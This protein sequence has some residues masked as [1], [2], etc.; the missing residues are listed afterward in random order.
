MAFSTD[1]A[2]CRAKIEDT[3]GTDAEPARGTDDLVVTKGASIQMGVQHAEIELE[4][5]YGGLAPAPRT[6]IAPTISFTV[7]LFG[8]GFGG[9][10]SIIQQTAFMSAI[11]QSCGDIDISGSSGEVLKWTP[12]TWDTK[13]F[14]DESDSATDKGST[15]TFEGD[16]GLKG[17][18]D[19]G[20]TTTYTVVGCRVQS[21]RFQLN[22]QG[23]CMC[24]VTAAGVYASQPADVTLDSGTALTDYNPTF[25]ADFITANGL[26]TIFGLTTAGTSQTAQSNNFEISVDFGATHVSGDDAESGVS[27]TR[28]GQF[29]VTATANPVRVLQSTWDYWDQIFSPLAESGSARDKRYIQT[30]KVTPARRAADEGYSWQFFLPDVTYGGE[31]ERGGEVHRHNMSVRA[32]DDF[33]GELMYIQVT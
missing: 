20:T 3:E 17:R 5:P 24:E 30:S 22:A 15:F 25:D 14:I 2:I 18:P 26:T 29:R 13:S 31:D 23:V 1:F 8:A 12:N 9:D 28:N 19:S 11:L 10:P 6:V 4:S 27:F 33:D 7:P 21:L 32:V 16:M